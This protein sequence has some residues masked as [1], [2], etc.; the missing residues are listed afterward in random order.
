MVLTEIVPKHI[1]L[2]Q[3]SGL[4]DK[5]SKKII[6]KSS[7]IPKHTLVPTGD[8]FF[9][10]ALVSKHIQTS[11][12]P[13]PSYVDYGF[14]S[15]QR[16]FSGSHRFAINREEKIRDQDV[17]EKVRQAGMKEEYIEL[18]LECFRCNPIIDRDSWAEYIPWLHYWYAR[19]LWAEAV[20]AVL[21]R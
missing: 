9:D 15:D 5:P 14:G 6:W 17:N 8:M 20:R 10:F 2:T 11:S 19:F 16:I 12:S 21:R 13:T 18:C 4:S 3:F 7:D 1:K